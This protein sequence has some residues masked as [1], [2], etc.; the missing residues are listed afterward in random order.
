M[1]P[2]FVISAVV[3]AFLLGRKSAEKKKPKKG[4]S[5]TQLPSL[6]ELPL[7]DDLPELPDLPALP[8]AWTDSSGAPSQ[9]QIK[10]AAA[11]A[12]TAFDAEIYPAGADKTKI[13]PPSTAG[14]ISTARDCSIVAVGERWWDRAGQVA[15]SLERANMLTLGTLERALFPLHCRGARAP[16]IDALRAEL[17]ER[18]GLDPGMLRNRRHR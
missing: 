7:P 1:H 10:N 4:A 6:G 12:K 18:A 14:G 9:A 13:A 11:W 16:G 2:I 15:E 17:A 3:S 8:P 5:V